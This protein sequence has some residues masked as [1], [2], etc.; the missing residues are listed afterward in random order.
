MGGT[1]F[2]YAGQ[3]M[4]SEMRMLSA[5]E[6]VSLQRRVMP[7]FSDRIILRYNILRHVS[8][9]QPIGRRA[10]AQSLG[11]SERHVRREENVLR[12]AGLLVVGPDGIRLS[13]DGEDILRDLAEYVGLLVGAQRLADLL[14]HE[15]DLERA[16]VITGNSDEDEAVKKEMAR[17]GACVL[18][19]MISDGDVV[20]VC[21]GTT[22]AELAAQT[23]P[24]SGKRNVVVVPARGSLG[25]DVEKQADTVAALMAKKLGGVYRILNLPDDLGHELA[26]SVAEEPRTKEVLDTIRQSRIVVHGVG[27]AV[28]MARRRNMSPSEIEEIASLGAVGEAFGFYF[29]RDGEVV[30]ITSSLG[31]RVS[32]LSAVETVMCVGGGSS[33]GQALAAVLRNGFSHIVVTDEGAA[34][35]ALGKTVDDA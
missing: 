22:M 23:V 6:I 7:E 21:G 10:L 14:Q 27:T 1:Q 18:R 28:E 13:E 9:A 8:H 11:E 26:A 2:D 24:A 5:A 19:D 35:E 12:T 4:S 29:D 17:V 30:Y 25:E 20:A 32:D 3:K 16:I 33:K 34:R 31:L 15:F